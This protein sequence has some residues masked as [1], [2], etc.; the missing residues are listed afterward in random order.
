MA[1]TYSTTQS[2]HSIGDVARRHKE[3]GTNS[4]AVGQARQR[5]ALRWMYR[6]GWSTPSIIDQVANNGRSGLAARLVK[7][8]LLEETDNP[9]NRR[10]TDPID[11]LFLT[12][13]A[14][15]EV[16]ELL[17]SPSDFLDQNYQN[18]LPIHQVRHD[19]YVQKLTANNINKIKSYLTPKEIAAKSK[20]QE[21]QVDAIWIYEDGIRVGIEMELTRKKTGREIDR[22]MLMILLAV[23]DGNT[24]GLN[25]INFFSTSRGILETYKAI[26]KPGKKIR[27]WEQDDQRRWVATDLATVPDWSEN[28]ILFSHFTPKG[29]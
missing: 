14:V 25:A 23:K 18:D 29:S 10:S 12:K 17:D 15:Q 5:E 11:L 16:E 7:R 20:P 13:D 1:D 6:W 3:A 4:R 22:S 26:L 8:G 2:N 28:R 19:F 9:Q 27:R 24:F 21:K